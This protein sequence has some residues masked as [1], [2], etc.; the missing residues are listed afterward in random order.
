M[1]SGLGRSPGEEN[2]NPFQNS[3]LGNPLDRGA[4]QVTVHRGTRTQLND[5]HTH[6]H[7]HAH[8]HMK[9]NQNSFKRNVKYWYNY[10]TSNVLAKAFAAE[11]GLP[12]ERE[13][14]Y[15]FQ[16]FSI[17]LLLVLFPST[18][19]HFQIMSAYLNPTFLLKYYTI[20]G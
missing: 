10:F 17:L 2:G 12:L 6:T 19:I 15:F 3:C 18:K 7:T 8:T 5:T 20:L 16:P 4:W 13:L 14:H 11:T 9:I 1:I